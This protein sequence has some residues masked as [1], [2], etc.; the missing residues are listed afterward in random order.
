MPPPFKNYYKYFLFDATD[1]IRNNRPTWTNDDKKFTIGTVWAGSPAV[2]AWYA[3]CR[4]QR[5]NSVGFPNP[6][7][8]PALPHT[9]ADWIIAK[10]TG[11]MPIPPLPPAAAAVAPAAAINAAVAAALPVA[12]IARIVNTIAVLAAPPAPFVDKLPHHFWPQT[13]LNVDPGFPHL[14]LAEIKKDAQLKN[15][16]LDTRPHL[17]PEDDQEK[18]WRGVR[19]LGAGG[20]GAAGLWVDLDGTNNIVDRMVIKE[21]KSHRPR[22]WRDPR[23]WRD[24]TPQEIRIHELVEDRRIADPD[25]CHH[26]VHMRNSRLFMRRRKYRIYLDFYPGGSLDDAISYHDENWGRP[27]ARINETRYLPEAYIWYVI[28]ALVEACLVLRKGT[29]NAQ[30]IE[31][32]KPITHLDLQLPNVLLGWQEEA[33]VQNKSASAKGKERAVAPDDTNPFLSPVYPVLTDFGVSFFSPDNN[34]NN[35]NGYPLS[36]NPDDYILGRPES[37]YP[38]EKQLQSADNPIFLGEPADVWGIGRIAWQLITNRSLTHG[39]VRDPPM[40]DVSGRQYPVFLSSNNPLNSVKNDANTTLRDDGY[41]PAASRYSIKL[42]EV[43]SECL[44]FNTQHRPR[45]ERLHEDATEELAVQGIEDVLQDVEGLGLR[46][47]GMDDFKIGGPIDLTQYRQRGTVPAR[48]F[49][50]LSDV[51]DESPELPRDTDE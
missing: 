50:D 35:N 27:K 38:P 11:A 23:M 1:Y 51:P 45:L 15:T 49:L 7:P 2:K 29:T 21:T 36:D 6:N 25:M 44:N 8:I 12:I 14:D 37:R 28:K 13:Y 22:T 24:R 33:D 20:F 40:E 31:G 34:N 47:P 26:L 5:N 17:V 48:P 43:V 32:W 10:A 3:Q 46:L 9:R 39:P 4:D 41:F 18:D 30:P 19:Y 16:W 42:R